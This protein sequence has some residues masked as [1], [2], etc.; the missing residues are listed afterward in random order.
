MSK[1]SKTILIVAFTFSHEKRKWSLDQVYGTSF[2]RVANSLAAVL[3]SS[4]IYGILVSFYFL[5]R[6]FSLTSQFILILES[7]SGH[8][9][10]SC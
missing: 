7:A 1:R 2:S 5:T 10:L 3:E 4:I 9:C 8:D 6:E